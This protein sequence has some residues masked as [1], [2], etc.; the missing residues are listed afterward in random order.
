[1]VDDELQ[2][3]GSADAQSFPV[4]GQLPDL[5]VI[6]P[7]RRTALSPHLMACPELAESGTR[8]GQLP[9]EFDETGIE[10]RW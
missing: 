7:D 2:A 4:E 6:D 1:M 8:Q 3:L 5:R 10:L 9:G